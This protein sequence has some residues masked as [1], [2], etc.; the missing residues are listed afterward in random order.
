MNHRFSLCGLREISRVIHI[1]DSESTQKEMLGNSIES[2]PPP[3]VLAITSFRQ[4]HDDILTNQTR[5]QR[6]CCCP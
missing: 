4:Y 5:P 3:D 1:Y 2:L 6:N